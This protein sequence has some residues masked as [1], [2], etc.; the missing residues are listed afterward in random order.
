MSRL[1]AVKASPKFTPF[2][3]YTWRAVDRLVDDA[4]PGAFNQVRVLL[5][6]RDGVAWDRQI[7]TTLTHP[8]SFFGFVHAYTRTHIH[9]GAHGA[10]CVLF[11]CFLGWMSPARASNGCLMDGLIDCS[12]RSPSTVLGRRHGVQASEPH[13]RGLPAPGPV[14]KLPGH[15]GEL[16]NR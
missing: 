5:G 15:G 9:A 7:H 16:G 2:V 12:P 10:R 11:N 13:L 14:P 3:K 1:R 4:K 6:G 8:P